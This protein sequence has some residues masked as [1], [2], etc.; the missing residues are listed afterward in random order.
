MMVDIRPWRR[1]LPVW[2]P[3]VILCL[4]A[5]V[6]YVWQTSESGGR[7]SQ[8]RDR[9][10]DLEAE[11]GRL[12]GLMRATGSDRERV[13]EL[14][15]QFTTLR[16]EIQASKMRAFYLLLVGI[17]LV[18]LAAYLAAVEP[19]MY[20]NAA[21][22]LVLLV[23]VLA[24]AA[25]QNSIIRAGRFIREYVEP[26]IDKANGWERWLE[27]N[28]GFREVDRFFFGGFV[29]TFIAF[30]VVTATLSLVQL[31]ATNR[32]IIPVCAAALY[33]LSLLCVIIVLIRHWH[34]CTSTLDDAPESDE[35]E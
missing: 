26:S 25:E 1:L 18:V 11:L 33:G 34:S 20:T 28:H 30:F 3:A 7:R 35:P 21:I 14:E 6:L 8:V 19:K 22:P 10:V 12:E 2:L 16:T 27:S 15:Q 5:A 32:A 9:V 17:M 29:L 4:A 24:F 13:V 23:L 31:N